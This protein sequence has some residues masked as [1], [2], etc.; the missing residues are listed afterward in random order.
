MIP[1]AAATEVAGAFVR[2]DFADRAG[3]A[4]LRGDPERPA[5]RFNRRGEDALY[6]SPDAESAWIGIRSIAG[7]LDRP[8]VVQAY[9]V[10]KARVLDMRHP[11]AAAIYEEARQPWRMAL[12]DGRAPQSWAVA[13]IVRAAE[14][15]GLIDPSRQSPGRWA[16]TLFRWE[17]TDA[18]IVHPHGAA[19]PFVP[20][21]ARIL[22]RP[23][24]REAPQPRARAPRSRASHRLP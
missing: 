24:R 19:V 8:R 22:V 23:A 12:R 7:E 10:G 18:P 20:W 1:K 21:Q 14:L 6:L 13:D 2:I 11:D 9:V 3:R 17:G 15:D 16:L 5:A 4:L